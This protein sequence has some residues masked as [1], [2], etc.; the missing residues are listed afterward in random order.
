V[1]LAAGKLSELNA[2]INSNPQ[3]VSESGMHYANGGTSMA[4][5]V[6]AGVAALYFSRCPQATFLDVKQAM[7]DHAIADVFTGPLPGYQMGWG[8]IDAWAT[9]SSSVSPIEIS[10]PADMLCDGASMDLSAESGFDNYL[11][12]NGGEGSALSILSGGSY[13]VEA[14]DNKGCLQRSETLIIET[15]DSPNVPVIEFENEQLMAIGEAAGWQWYLGETLIEGAIDP[16]FEPSTLGVYY[17]DAIG[18][19]GC[20]RRSDPYFFGVVGTDELLAGEMNI[21]PNPAAGFFMIDAGAE[22]IEA[23]SLYDVSGRFIRSGQGSPERK[24]VQRIQI[25]GLSPGVYVV[26]IQLVESDFRIGR[27]VV[28]N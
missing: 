27:L 17:V 24:S 25:D 11:W 2:L 20:A 7:I 26:H 3:K 6:A 23:W 16:V 12:S 5:P 4:S 15:L 13:F 9:L 22:A 14:H 21:Y 18:E 10:S 19:N 28:E 1:T 8:K